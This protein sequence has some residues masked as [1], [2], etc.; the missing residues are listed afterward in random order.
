MTLDKKRAIDGSGYESVMRR[1]GH[2]EI[3]LPLPLSPMSSN[4][5][6]VLLSL[7]QELLLALFQFFDIRSLVTC[8]QVRPFHSYVSVSPADS[9]SCSIGLPSFQRHSRRMPTVPI[10]ARLVY[11]RLRRW[12][13]SCPVYIRPSRCF[14]AVRE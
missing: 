13:D 12:A 7:P 9:T 1:V 6:L 8:R 5:E 11:R 14:E 2:M 3:R 10:Q 4:S